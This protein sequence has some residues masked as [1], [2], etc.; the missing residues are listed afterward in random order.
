[1]RNLAVVA[2]L[3]VFPITSGVAQEHDLIV[4]DAW[5]TPARVGQDSHVYLTV[6]NRGRVPFAVL[7]TSTL[8]SGDVVAIGLG[9]R[10]A[11][12]EA[13][14]SAFYVPANRAVKMVP[15][16]PH[17]VLGK[18]S[19]SLVEGGEVHLLLHGLGDETVPVTARVRAAPSS[20]VAGVPTSIS[21]LP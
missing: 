4:L 5:A 6:A 20:H 14:P 3:C 11:D 16:R 18:V 19:A 17:L 13:L 2:L 12:G 8:V 21:S 15:G 1:M 9:A 10:G 7:R